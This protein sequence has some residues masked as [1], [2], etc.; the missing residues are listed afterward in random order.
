MSI[1]QSEEREI[2]AY[3]PCLCVADRGQLFCSQICQN[4]LAAHDPVPYDCDCAH[5]K[6]EQAEDDDDDEETA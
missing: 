4:H 2:C 3:P 5:S 1:L 6:C